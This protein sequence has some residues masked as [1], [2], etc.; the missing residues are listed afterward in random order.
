MTME[1]VKNWMEEQCP[2]H[3]FKIS[4][5]DLYHL[6]TVGCWHATIEEDGYICPWAKHLLKDHN[7]IVQLRTMV[8]TELTRPN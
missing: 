8:R 3:E 1:H 7:V 6:D 4:D 2:G 5:G